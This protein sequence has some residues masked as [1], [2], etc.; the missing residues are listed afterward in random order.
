MWGGALLARI[1]L[2]E[3]RMFTELARHTRAIQESLATQISAIDDKYNNLPARVSQL[4][5]TVVP[6]KRR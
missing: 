3:Q 1:E 6:S 4:E 2:G 5:A